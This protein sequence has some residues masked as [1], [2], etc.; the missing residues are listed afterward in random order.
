MSTDWTA[1]WITSPTLP[2]G[3][4]PMPL[5]RRAFNLDRAPAVKHASI[6]ICGLGHFELRLNRNKVGEDV[7]ESGWTDYR[8]T[9]LS[10]TR[11]V[12]SLLL[13]GENVIGVLLGNGMYNVAGGRY[14]KF[15]GSFGP[16]KLI[17]ELAI[18]FDDGSTQLV[19]TDE[20]W[21]TTDGPVRFSCIYGGEDYDARFERN[22]WDG[23]QYD[24]SVW[25]SA[26]LCK[27]PGGIL[28]K[29]PPSPNRVMKTFDAVSAKDVA[30]GVRV[31]DMGQNMSGWPFVTLL[32]APGKTV[33]FKTGEVLD[34]RGR[35]SQ[36]NTGSPV[37]FTYTAGSDREEQWQPR[38]SLTGFR[39]VEASG[40]LDMLQ[41][42]KGQ[43]VHNAAGVVGGFECSNAMLNRIHELILAAIKSNMHSVFT[44]CPH[45]EKLGWLEQAHLMAPSILANVDAGPLF[46]KM[47]LDIR[48]A[49]HESGMVPTIAPQYTQF[50]PPWDVFN[51]SP[52]WGA[53]C[54][55][56]PW[57]L[58]QH[59]G[60]IQILRDNYDVMKRYIAYLESRADEKGIIAY[61]LGDWYDIGPGDPGFGKLT[62]L[63][64][65]GTATF[66]QCL[67]ALTHIAT[68]LGEHTDATSFH[69]RRDAARS[70][71]NNAFYD[72]NANRYDRGSQC[73]Q[74][75]ALA[76]NLCDDAN[77]ANV[78]DLLIAD[79][80][81]NG[82]HITAGDIGFRYVLVALAE[83]GRSDV[84]FDLLTQTTPPSYGAQL[85]AGATTLTEAWD[86]NPTKSLNHMMLGHAE[87]W[88]HCR[89]AGIQVNLAARD[90]EPQVIFAPTPVGDVTW[91]KAHRDL[92]VGRVEC[93]WKREGEAVTLEVT[94]PAGVRAQTRLPNGAR[95]DLGTGSQ[96]IETTIPPRA[97]TAR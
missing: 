3:S 91:A 73:A 56:A 71:F 48:D 39:Y 50:A 10:V 19:F 70:S 42:V 21:K 80:R 62:T 9:C 43:W 96:R 14:R 16:P 85:A 79:I 51:D 15:K 34:E 27:G 38:F 40:D 63:G 88:L 11:D 61:G 33:T 65:T 28:N 25:D 95:Q 78:L 97:S 4:G 76:L 1:S 49:Q 12:T 8:R 83:A 20:Q 94:V 59:T 66:I 46:G 72:A 44:D 57:C 35:V 64:V 84:I 75:M 87:E 32:G 18:A 67:T 89:L 58:Y 55:L 22:G 36:R 41:S 31:F 69:G 90:D 29:L 52:E 82:N 45:R 93:A 86:A 2:T 60:D 30:P 13:P 81:A 5:F 47:M 68:A 92:P 17:A 37:S 24:D 6:R 7:L 74:A 77:R 26:Q 53:A 23:Q 54:I